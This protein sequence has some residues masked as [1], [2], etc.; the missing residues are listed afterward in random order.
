M[1]TMNAVLD[2]TKETTYA[3]VAGL[4]GEMARLFTDQAVHI[5]GDEVSPAD[6]Q[7]T[8]GI[9][10]Y[11]KEHSLTPHAL[12]TYFTRR[13]VAIVK[14]LRKTPVVW[15]EA[16]QEQLPAGVVVQ[17]W[18]S[19]KMVQ[20]SA[21][22]G[23]PTIVSSGYYLDH[24]LPATTYYAV[25]P[26][27]SHAMGLPPEMLTAVKGTML[28]PYVTE[29][30][31]AADAPELTEDDRVR[32]K[33]GETALWTELVQAPGHEI[34]LWP[35]AAAV[36]E[37]LWSPRTIRDEV[38][39]RRRLEAVSSDLEALGLQHRSA[40]L[41]L[42]RRLAGNA[43]VTP[44]VT[45]AGAVE[46]QRYL[47]R[48][49]RTIMGLASNPVADLY[50]PPLNRL[51]DAVPPES[52]VALAFSEAAA[53]AIGGG[54]ER[55]AARAVVRARLETWR[56]NDAAF[57][58]VASGSALLEEIVPVSENI[59]SLAEAGLEALGALDHDTQLAPERA[60][61]L[62]ATLAPFLKEEAATSSVLGAVMK[63]HPT[64]GLRIAIVPG[65]S[66]LVEA[67]AAQ[68]H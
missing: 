34:H 66:T 48:L 42:L 41:V 54:E 3:F 17:A 16:L 29:A 13:V 15:D 8:P 60:A 46:P 18:R 11:M 63:P 5:A 37:R 9:Q 1:E 23:H 30:M 35:R 22:A 50:F 25:D 19:S 53:A 43:D 36:A 24:G 57:R 62:H 2:P 59:K 58:L 52:P 68:T 65:I 61:A 14:G 47:A 44:L 39:L 31:V 64:H 20:R 26:Y 21:S 10:A 45:L 49:I 6:W 32:I 4:L 55:A 56:D 7:E 67:A 28:E 51:A 40:S 27:D 33:G 12:Q 38:S